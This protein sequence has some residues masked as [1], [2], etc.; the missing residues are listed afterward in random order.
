M[1]IQVD[2]DKAR[3]SVRRWYARHREEYAALRKQRYASDPARRK[4]AREAA[5]HYREK[6]RKGLKVERILTREL[7]GTRVKVF[8]S[9]YVADQLKCS[10]QV[11]RNWEERGWVPPS[12]F[13]DVHRLYTLHQLELLHMLASTLRSGEYGLRATKGDEAGLKGLIE[14]IHM[15]WD[16]EKSS[17]APRKTKRK[18]KH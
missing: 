11:L 9:G 3:A 8:T 18:R 4:K 14:F 10:Q 16:K 5:A 7:N 15:M 17:H 6:R 2:R 1:E 13:P 12:V